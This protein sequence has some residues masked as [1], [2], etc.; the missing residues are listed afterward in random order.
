M[1]TLT[2][3]TASIAF[4]QGTWQLIFA[5]ITGGA[6]IIGLLIGLIFKLVIL[7]PIS[8]VEASNIELS[9]NIGD[10]ATAI[11]KLQEFSSV[12]TEKNNHDKDKLDILFKK[13]DKI[14]TEINKVEIIET[15]IKKVK[16]RHNKLGI[17]VIN[18]ESQIQDIQENI[19]KIGEQK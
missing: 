13:V 18:T 9:K 12:Q 6:T 2:T 14:E 3:G 15:D 1:D 17:R 19:K 4:D 8:K 16:Y 7:K 10:L 5:A 11:T